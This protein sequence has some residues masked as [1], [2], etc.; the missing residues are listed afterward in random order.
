MASAAHRQGV[1]VMSFIHTYQLFDIA[2]G[3]CKSKLGFLFWRLR[4]P[5]KQD[6][7]STRLAPIALK[8]NFVGARVVGDV[9]RPLLSLGSCIR[10]SRHA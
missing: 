10:N 2:L 5:L 7:H 3:P 6:G 4:R 8:P 1:G 9:I